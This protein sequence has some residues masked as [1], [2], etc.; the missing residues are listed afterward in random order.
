MSVSGWCG[1]NFCCCSFILKIGAFMIQ[2]D[3][4]SFQIGWFNHQ[5]VVFIYV[6]PDKCKASTPEESLFEMVNHQ[7]RRF[8]APRKAY[9]DSG[10]KDL[11]FLNL[12]IYEG[13]P[14][15]QTLSPM[16]FA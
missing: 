6:R 16:K 8:S 2:F 10:K 3:E 1:F 13:Y 11:N 12:E 14:C 9:I 7:R 4:H 5:L 15:D